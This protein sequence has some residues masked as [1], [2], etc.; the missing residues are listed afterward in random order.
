MEH[1]RKLVFL[2]YI[3]AST[4]LSLPLAPLPGCT[5]SRSGPFQGSRLPFEFYAIAGAPL[6]GHERCTRAIAAE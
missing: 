4:G 1:I 3:V 6:S 5:I 2:I